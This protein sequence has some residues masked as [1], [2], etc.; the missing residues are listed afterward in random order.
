MKLGVNIKQ[1]EVI[2]ALH[3]IIYCNKWKQIEGHENFV[4]GRNATAT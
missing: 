1:L 2:A 3:F 4:D